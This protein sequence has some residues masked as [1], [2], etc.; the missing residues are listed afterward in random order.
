[1]AAYFDMDVNATRLNW[2][3]D[4]SEWKPFH[5][6][7]AAMKEIF[8]RTQNFP[9]EKF[10]VSENFSFTVAAS[11]WKGSHSLESWYQL[12]LVAFTSIS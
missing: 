6:D 2:Y 10:C 8:A 11:W 5:N 7:A 3:R 12:S 4:S 1:M 9:K